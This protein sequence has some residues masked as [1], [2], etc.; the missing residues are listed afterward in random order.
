MSERKKQIRKHTDLEVYQRAFGA[1][2]RF[3]EL[4]R[5]FPT[6]ER[7]SLTDQGRR[8]SRSVCGNLAEA[9][10]KRRY[11]AAFVSKLNDCEGEA[12]ET[13]VWIQFAV[14]CGYLERMDAKNLYS[15]YDSILGMLVSMIHHPKPWLLP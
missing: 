3:F 1:G 11:E 10:R 15:E 4:S 6:E 5:K 2:M 13:Q 9:W 12:A 14:K 7:Y 8:S